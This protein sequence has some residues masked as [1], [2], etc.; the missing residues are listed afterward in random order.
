MPLMT[1]ETTVHNAITDVHGK[2]IEVTQGVV[3]WIK[4][5]EKTGRFKKKWI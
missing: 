4:L 5:T 3:Y 2:F 1:G